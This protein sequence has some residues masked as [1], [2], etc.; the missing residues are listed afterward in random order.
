MAKIGAVTTFT[1]AQAVKSMLT[2]DQQNI[3]SVIE[4]FDTTG[5]QGHSSLSDT[6]QTSSAEVPAK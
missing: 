2:A 6:L 5:A 1:M 3:S 4:P